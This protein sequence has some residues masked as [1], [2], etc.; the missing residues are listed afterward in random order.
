MSKRNETKRRRL[1][2]LFCLICGPLLYIHY[3]DRRFNIT[4][5]SYKFYGT[6]ITFPL[7]VGQAIT[8]YKVLPHKYNRTGVS[9]GSPCPPNIPMNGVSEVFY[10]DNADDYLK[11]PSDSLLRSIYA[12]KFC[13]AQQNLSLFQTMKSQLEKDFKSK[14]TLE[15]HREDREPYYRLNAGNDVIIVIEFY[16]ELTYV[17]D[18]SKLESP[19]SWAVSFCCNT[20][21]FSVDHYLHY[22]R[23]YDA[24]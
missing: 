21:N 1:A 10:V 17:F 24:Q 23:N 11:P 6:Q 4:Y 8:N 7:T 14:F 22:E 9:Y 3:C 5:F 20:F 18:Q 19:R 13:F 15:H 12:V 2:L 16:P